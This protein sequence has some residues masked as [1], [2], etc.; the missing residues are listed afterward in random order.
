MVCRLFM[1]NKKKKKSSSYSRDSIGIS[2][3]LL[4]GNAER[5]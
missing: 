2:D 1:V 5:N 3:I 4:S